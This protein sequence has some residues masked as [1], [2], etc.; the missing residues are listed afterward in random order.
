MGS[1]PS[2]VLSSSVFNNT[3]ARADGLFAWYDTSNDDYLTLESSAITQF[4][5][6]SGNGYHSDVQGTAS[7]RPTRTLDQQNGLQAAVFDDDSLV[8]PSPVHAIANGNNTVFVVAKRDTEDGGIDTIISLTESGGT[9]WGVRFNATAGEVQYTSNTSSS[10]VTS[11]GNTNTDFQ[12]LTGYRP[13]SSV[14][15][16]VNGGAASSTGNAADEPGVD[17]ASIGVQSTASNPLIGSVAE[18]I[19][20]DL[21]LTAAE[22]LSVNTY[23]SI[24]WGISI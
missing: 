10:A 1:V 24:K 14:N 5:D 3:P 8:L 7:K 4:L 20:Y 15:L 22:I 6:R 17:L 21:S 9:R 19:I 16:S 18:I 2:F 12:I 23:L 11:S 13:G